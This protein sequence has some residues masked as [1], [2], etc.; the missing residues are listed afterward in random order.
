M[1]ILF[2]NQ[3]YD[4]S[5]YKKTLFNNSVFFLSSKHIIIYEFIK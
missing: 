1:Q 5:R 4:I 3:F 2:A